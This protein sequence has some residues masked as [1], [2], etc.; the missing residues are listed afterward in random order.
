MHVTLT[1]VLLRPGCTPLVCSTRPLITK[2]MF[3]SL[4]TGASVLPALCSIADILLSNP[5]AAATRPGGAPLQLT[6]YAPLSAGAQGNYRGGNVAFGM[7]RR[8]GLWRLLWLCNLENVG[9]YTS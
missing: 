7:V 5:G 2:H 6:C 3:A 1:W 4:S 8:H 9:G